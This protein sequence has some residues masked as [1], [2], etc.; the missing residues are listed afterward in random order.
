MVLHGGEQWLTDVPKLK[1]AKPLTSKHY[2]ELQ[3]NPRFADTD[4]DMEL[5]MAT[6]GLDDQETEV[7][8]RQPEEPHV[9]YASTEFFDIYGFEMEDLYVES[10]FSSRDFFS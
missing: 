8:L 4:C 2:M 6:N 3:Y 5:L 10:H 1:A 9:E 7:P